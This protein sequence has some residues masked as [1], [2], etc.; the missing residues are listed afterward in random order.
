MERSITHFEKGNIL[1]V[2][3]RLERSSKTGSENAGDV[4]NGEGYREELFN[5]E[6]S[7]VLTGSYGTVSPMPSRS[8][9]RRVQDG[10]P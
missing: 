6:V 8:C 9:N 4:R 7:R 2:T 3:R 5:G 1:S 10:K